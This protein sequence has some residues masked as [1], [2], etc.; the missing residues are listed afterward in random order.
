MGILRTLG[1]FICIIG[2]FLMLVDIAATPLLGFNTAAIARYVINII[3][4]VVG[5]KLFKRK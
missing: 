2:V 5:Y 4:I 3:L 1:L